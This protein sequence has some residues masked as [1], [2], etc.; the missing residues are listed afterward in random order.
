MKRYE[1]TDIQWSSVAH[2]FPVR[3]GKGRPSRPART[4][5]DGLLWV[6]CSGAAWRDLPER[7]G[8]WKTV[9]HRFRVWQRA[10]LFEQILGVLNMQLNEK[11][12][13]DWGLWEVD[14]TVVKASKA[15]SG[16]KK[17]PTGQPKT[18]PSAGRRAV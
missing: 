15:A 8:P 17:K 6:L 2:F 12:L 14:S 11:G 4:I 13:I 3:T 10:G 5:F 16:A 1:L 7:Y 9:Y 18:R